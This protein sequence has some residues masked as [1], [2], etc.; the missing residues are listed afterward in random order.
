VQA[1]AAQRVP[2]NVVA[3]TH[4]LFL[5]SRTL[6]RSRLLSLSF[7]LRFLS[8]VFSRSLPLVFLLSLSCSLSLSLASS[9]PCA[10]SL[11]LALALA[12]LCFLS[13]YRSFSL[14]PYLLSLISRSSNSHHSLSHSFSL[15]HSLSFAL[16]LSLHSLSRLVISHTP[17]PPPFTHSFAVPRRF[18]N[19]GIESTFLRVRVCVCVC[20]RAWWGGTPF[21]QSC[22]IRL[23]TLQY[24]HVHTHVCVYVYTYVHTCACVPYVCVVCVCVCVLSSPASVLSSPASVWLGVARGDE[25]TG[26][27]LLRTTV[28]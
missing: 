14:P 19:S 17:F 13:L 1:S 25:L 7:S 24:T 23:S 4:S 6:S 20:S 11:F 21:L 9:L 12:L 27:L 28:S 5:S 8:L 10:R 15:S 16:L 26:S 3:I 22:A 18:S 2:P